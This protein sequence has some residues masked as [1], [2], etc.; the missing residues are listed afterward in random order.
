MFPGKTDEFKFYNLA[1]SDQSITDLYNQGSSFIVFPIS[2]LPINCS[3]VYKVVNNCIITITDNT[4]INTTLINNIEGFSSSSPI[5]SPCILSFAP[6]SPFSSIGLS[7]YP[8][9]VVGA[10][11]YCS[12]TA[13][14]SKPPTITYWFNAPNN[15]SVSKTGIIPND[16]NTLIQIKCIKCDG[17]QIVYLLNNQIVMAYERILTD[18]LYLY[19]YVLGC[20]CRVTESTRFLP[21]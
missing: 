11:Y 19:T 8:Y 10:R 7:E 12:C 15:T 17:F 9:E 3:N 1:L 4:P 5:S 18:P 6:P 20:V 2:L 21:T 14:N 16:K 13:D